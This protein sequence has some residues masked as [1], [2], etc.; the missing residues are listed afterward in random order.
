MRL[1]PES[2]LD[3]PLPK[4]NCDML[5][6]DGAACLDISLLCDVQPKRALLRANAESRDF[7]Q[8]WWTEELLDL[9]GKNTSCKVD[10][11]MKGFRA[12]LIELEF[13]LDGLTY[14]LST[15]VRILEP[16]K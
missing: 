16:K 15:P 10:L 13:E 9:T 8:C 14:H 1:L 12:A 7:R 3:R 4:L 6:P 5:C 11:P 2:D